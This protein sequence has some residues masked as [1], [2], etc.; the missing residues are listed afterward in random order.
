MSLHVGIFAFSGAFQPPLNL[1]SISGMSARN[2]GDV[3]RLAAIAVDS[4]LAFGRQQS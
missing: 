1:R 4:G 2:R 3:K